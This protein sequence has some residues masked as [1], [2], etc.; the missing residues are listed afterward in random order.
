MGLITTSKAA[1]VLGITPVRVR[2]LI[3]TRALKSE[4]QGRD[5]LLDE[6]E[7]ERFNRE[8]RRRPGRP[9]KHRRKILRMR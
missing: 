9:T 5:H 8:G 4:K 7:V 3:K 1:K 6:I 2:Q